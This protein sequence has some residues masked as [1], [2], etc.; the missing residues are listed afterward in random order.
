MINLKITNE[1][2]N[3]VFIIRKN[4]IL[5]LKNLK[6]LLMVKIEIKTLLRSTTICSNYWMRSLGNGYIIMTVW[7][8]EQRTITVIAVELNVVVILNVDVDI[9]PTLVKARQLSLFLGSYFQVT[10]GLNCNMNF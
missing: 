7:D 10:F 6:Y 2:Y 5:N 4:N 3:V 8:V 9:W 1:K